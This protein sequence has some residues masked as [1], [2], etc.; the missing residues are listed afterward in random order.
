MCYGV[1]EQGIEPDLDNELPHGQTKEDRIKCAGYDM[2]H[3]QQ[4]E[5]VS[6]E[7]DDG[8]AFVLIVGG[9]TGPA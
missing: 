3:Q 6:E 8:D 9:F 5:Q 2:H 7:Q 1:G 4:I